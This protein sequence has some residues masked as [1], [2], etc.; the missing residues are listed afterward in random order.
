V[1]IWT[2]GSPIFGPRE[3]PEIW[4]TVIQMFGL[5]WGLQNCLPWGPPGPFSGR[6]TP[7]GP[8]MSNPKT[9]KP[10]SGYSPDQFLRADFGNETK[11]TRQHE[12]RGPGNDV[13]CQNI[14]A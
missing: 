5:L 8:K 14:A 4:I 6:R 13:R 9:A 3:A 10:S 12:T 2:S 7:R 1:V 11:C